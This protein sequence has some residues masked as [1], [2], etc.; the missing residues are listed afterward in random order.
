[1]TIYGIAVTGSLTAGLAWL[2]ML[3]LQLV[4]AVV[5]FRLDRESLRPL[6]SLPLQQFVYRQLLYVILIRAIAAALAGVALRWHKLKRTGAAAA[7]V[8]GTVDGPG[9]DARAVTP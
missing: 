6:W 5:A 4:T 9:S 1:M 2:A 8:A 3:G 7:H